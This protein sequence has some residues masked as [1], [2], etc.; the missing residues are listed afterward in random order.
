MINAWKKW[1]DGS[2]PEKLQRA[3]GA[4]VFLPRD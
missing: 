3:G 4:G 1:P 2:Y